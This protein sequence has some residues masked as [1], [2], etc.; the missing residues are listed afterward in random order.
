MLVCMM[1][2]DSGML[3]SL[4][5]KGLMRGNG[6][7]FNLD[8]FGL[9]VSCIF[10]DIRLVKHSKSLTGMVVDLGSLKYGGKYY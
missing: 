8:K 9:D 3:P 1:R 4:V 5:V 2:P 6:L 7:K 10:H